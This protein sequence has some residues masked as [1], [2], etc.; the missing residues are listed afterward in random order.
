MKTLI[1]MRHAKSDWS[2][3]LEDHARPLNPRGREAAKAVGQHLRDTAPSPDL[4]LIS[5]A[6]RTRETWERM[7]WRAGKTEFRPDL[8][9]ASEGTLLDLIKA[10]DPSVSVLFLLGHNP[11]FERL[12]AVLT[13]GNPDQ[14]A[15]ITKPVPNPYQTQLSK[16]FPTA[17]TMILEAEVDTWPEISSETCDLK[18][19]L[20]PKSLPEN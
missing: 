14:T 2:A 9:H 20:T 5:D 15:H 13:S 6:T 3:G 17:A 16:P 7:G 8:Y 11:G 19:Y 1:L 12:S 18:A 10:Q 4:A